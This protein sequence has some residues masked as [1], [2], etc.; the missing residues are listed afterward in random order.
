[1]SPSFSAREQLRCRV[2]QAA[3]DCK[4]HHKCKSTLFCVA[5][6]LQTTRQL[7]SRWM[8]RECMDE[9]LHDRPRSGAPRKLSGA[10]VERAKAL[11]AAA[12]P[13]S[14]LRKVAKKLAVEG[15]CSV[16]VSKNTVRSAVRSGCGALRS[17]H[18]SSV[19]LL[20]YEQKKKR[21]AFARQNRTRAWKKVMFSDSKYF[22]LHQLAGRK[23]P[24]R[25][26]L[27]GTKPTQPSIKFPSKVHVYAGVSYYGKT[28][29]RF[30][31]GTTGL[32]SE[33][34][35]MQRGVGAAEYQTILGD[36]L[37][38]QAQKLF[39]RH[40]VSDWIFQQ[41][42]APAHTAIATREFLQAKGVRV[43]ADWPPNSPDLSWIENIWS[44]TEQQLRK[45]HFS[46]LSELK[47][48]LSRVW[49]EMPLKILQTNCQSMRNRL[50]KCIER[51]GGHI[52]Y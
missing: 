39:S 27:A 17:C 21:V 26:V 28:E 36:T 46:T 52:G 44:W 50:K 14:T 40:C 25:W 24:K 2:L 30:A 45:S 42:G 38:S 13:D 10:A 18:M 34:S 3:S 37:L 1:M 33:F 41:D 6:N 35:K 48:E 4:K 32:Q 20:T 16:E 9:G 31:T 8:K 49:N 43:L 5:R 15:L 23:G 51:E 47:V 11:L 29:L 19:P 7:V 12:K 22:Y